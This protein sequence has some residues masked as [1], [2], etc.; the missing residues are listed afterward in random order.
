MNNGSMSALALRWFLSYDLKEYAN[1]R[2]YSKKAQAL[3]SD[4]YSITTKQNY[5]TLKSLLDVH[6]IKLA[7]MQYPMRSI[8]PLKAI[9]PSE[10]GLVFVD[11]E[12]LF[13]G[14]VLREGYKEYFSDMFAGDFGHCTDKGNW[15]LAENIA[16][17]IL[18][19]R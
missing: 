5:N 7:C 16:N 3:T 4:F 2:K 12:M 8:K 1:A 11:N 18:K 15:L 17:A 6:G 19:W 14:A 9:F 13:K 10:D